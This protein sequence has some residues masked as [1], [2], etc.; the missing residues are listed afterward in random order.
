VSFSSTVAWQRDVW[1][2]MGMP[3]AALDRHL[4]PGGLPYY[5]LMHAHGLI[6]DVEMETIEGLW[7]TYQGDT[8]DLLKL[9]VQLLA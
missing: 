4:A 3:E 8:R 6:S 9:V 2:S 5:R 1:S 7:P